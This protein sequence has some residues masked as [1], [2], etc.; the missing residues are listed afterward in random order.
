MN[1]FYKFDNTE[2]NGLYV[3]PVSFK[4]IETEKAIK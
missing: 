3:Y 4:N 2:I 1:F